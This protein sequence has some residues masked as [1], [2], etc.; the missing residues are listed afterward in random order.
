[1][2]RAP[3]LGTRGCLSPSL[4]PG[5]LVKTMQSRGPA[6]S[7][8]HRPCWAGCSSFDSRNVSPAPRRLA[9]SWNPNPGIP[10]PTDSHLQLQ[11]S[12]LCRVWVSPGGHVSLPRLGRGGEGGRGTE[13]M[14]PTCVLCSPGC[15]ITPPAGTDGQPFPGL[16][17][18]QPGGSWAPPTGPRRAQ[19]PTNRP[20]ESASCQ[21]NGA[22][23]NNGALVQTR[24][25][26]SEVTL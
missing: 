12:S 18:G 17:T 26:A 20:P 8:S 13:S 23:T 9:G 16:G 24:F 25:L 1:M 2:L 19:G 14:P 7:G 5:A 6:A 11:Q 3:P 4:L 15:P 10:T 21:G 22:R